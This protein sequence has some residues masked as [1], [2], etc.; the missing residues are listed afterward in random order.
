MFY[1]IA[2]PYSSP[3][4]QIRQQRY[5]SVMGYVAYLLKRRI[6]CY[7]PILHT[8]ELSIQ[9]ALPFEYEFWHD[10]NCAMIRPSLGLHILMLQGWEASRGIAAEIAF[11]GSNSLP[12]EYVKAYDDNGTALFQLA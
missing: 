3:S 2:S 9:T 6:P 7:S 10:Y 12:I 4:P 5:E 11:A 1:Y 8:H